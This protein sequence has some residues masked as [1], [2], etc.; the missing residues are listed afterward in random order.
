M[1]QLPSR[2]APKVTMKV[3]NYPLVILSTP[4]SLRS[5]RRDAACSST[6]A[7][8]SRSTRTALSPEVATGQRGAPF[9]VRRG[10]QHAALY[11]YEALTFKG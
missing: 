5:E 1:S 2:I 8:W 11:R 6:S 7:A 3:C 4:R 9:Y 10:G